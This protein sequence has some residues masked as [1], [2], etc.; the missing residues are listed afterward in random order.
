MAATHKRILVLS[1]FPPGR[2]P[3]QRF[4]FEQYLSTWE[5]AGFEVVQREFWDRE[6]A[7]ILYKKGRTARKALG[8]ARGFARRLRTVLGGET[9][10]YVFVHLG[11]VPAGPPIV[12]ALCLLRG[13]RV[14][15]DIDDAIFLS[16]TSAANPAA[17]LLR[18]GKFIEY[19]TRRAETVV[20]VNPFLERWAKERNPRVRL[21]PTTIDPAYH[22]PRPP[23][24]EGEVPVL[25]W[26]GTFSTS[27]FLDLI[28]P[29]LVELQKTHDF[30]LRVVCDVDPKFPE[31]R[32]YT[33]L[34]WRLETEIEDLWPID[35]GLM[36]VNDSEM[37]KAKVGFK[38]I[39]YSALEIPSVVS[40]EG[41]GR[42][43]VEDG[44]TGLVVRNDVAAWVSALKTLLDDP[45][46]RKR[47]GV[48]AREKIMGRYSVPAQAP[49]YLSLV[50][51]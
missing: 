1:P 42:E 32:R 11:A 26:T 47:M 13:W 5:R 4:R 33:Y 41:S 23:S 49:A 27:A 46:R 35:V 10:D 12:E 36:P 14:I 51:A 2:M 6:T 24:A 28:R 39:Q 18:S 50:G 30:E 31:L 3:S 34:P 25:G 7:A 21:I 15:Y 9:F 48:A 44:V 40:D 22:R 38:A 17:R 20:V 29:A 43:V 37:A 19:V 45:S 8:F 16:I